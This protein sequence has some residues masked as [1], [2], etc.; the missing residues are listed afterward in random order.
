MLRDIARQ[1]IVKYI[2]KDVNLITLVLVEVLEYRTGT[3][4]KFSNYPTGSV[5]AMSF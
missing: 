3:D 1:C 4:E 5:L 2:G